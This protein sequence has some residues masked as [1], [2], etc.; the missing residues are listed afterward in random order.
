MLICP[1]Q[2]TEIDLIRPRIYDR[3]PPD[4]QRHCVPV[5]KMWQ[6]DTA[7][8]VYRASRGVFGVEIHSQVMAVGSGVPGVLLYPPQ[9]GSKGEMWK[10]IGLSDWFISTDSPGCTQRAVTV[11]RE[12]L[13]DPAGCA[14]KLRRARKIID[15]AN[16]S[17][18]EKT[19]LK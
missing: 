4:V 1:E 7:L 17:A 3:L 10:S 15:H 19:F 5:D 6:A 14:E 16:R 12:V 18:I 11:A 13:S 9:W 8:G 2:I